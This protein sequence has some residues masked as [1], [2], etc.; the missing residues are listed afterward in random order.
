MSYY[1]TRAVARYVGEQLAKGNAVS[2]FP[3]D[4]QRALWVDIP[5]THADA[6]KIEVG[7]RAFQYDD[8]DEWLWKY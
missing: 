4:N 3:S 2:I 8:W 5:M 6:E 1:N 7:S